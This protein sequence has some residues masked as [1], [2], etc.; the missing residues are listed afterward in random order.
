MKPADP[1]SRLYKL[2]VDFCRGRLDTAGFCDQFEQTYNLDLDRKTLTQIEAE[3]FG[4]LF[5]KV[6]WYSPYPKER[7]QISNYVGEAE[8]RKAAAAVNEWIPADE[9]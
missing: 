7:A 2:V 4:A 6:I 8:V 9:T 5:E 1:K 3:S